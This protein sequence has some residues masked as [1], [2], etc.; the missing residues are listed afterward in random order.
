[1]FN[2]LRQFHSFHEQNEEYLQPMKADG[3]PNIC[4][5]NMVMA[6]HGGYCKIPFEGSTFPLKS[7][8]RSDV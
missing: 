1:M 7:S 3:I 4:H 2:T 5:S 6:K 8:M